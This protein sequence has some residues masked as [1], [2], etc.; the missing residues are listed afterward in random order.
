MNRA[1]PLAPVWMRCG[2]REVGTLR[3][4]ARRDA[5]RSAAR[6][7]QDL[8]EVVWIVACGMGICNPVRVVNGLRALSFTA[9]N[10]RRK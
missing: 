1:L 2:Q 4:P 7:A 10:V 3:L 8:E 9:T 6:R 5:G